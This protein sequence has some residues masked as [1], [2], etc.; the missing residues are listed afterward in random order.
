MKR[1]DRLALGLA[2][3]GVLLVAAW[4]AVAPPAKLVGQGSASKPVSAA[5]TPSRVV[6]TPLPAQ[7]RTAGVPVGLA[8]ITATPGAEPPPLFTYNQ[9]VTPQKEDGYT[10]YPVKIDVDQ[11]L[12]AALSGRMT[13]VTPDGTKVSL[14]YD[15]HITHDDGNW[16]WIGREDSDDTKTDSVITFGSNATFGTLPSVNGQQLKLTTIH[17]KTYLASAPLAQLKEGVRP[18]GDT[19]VTAGGTNVAASASPSVVTSAAPSLSGTIPTVDVMIGF[20]TGY[21]A[22]R[23]GTDVATT[24]ITN[25]VDN[26]N[27]ILLN[28]NVQADF[29]LVGTMEVAYPDTGDN[30]DTLS[31]LA[32]GSTAA[33]PGSLRFYR[34]QYGAD[35]VSLVRRYDTS[36]NGCGIAYIPQA[37]Y[38]TTGP[39]QAFS[40]IG[41]GS[42]DLG[43]G[44]T[45]YCAVTTLAHEMGHNLGAQHNRQTNSTGGLFAFSYGYRNDSAGFYDVMSYGLDG[46]EAERL[47]ST[48]NRSICKGLPCGDAASADVARTL[49]Q[50]MPIAATF[51]ATVGPPVDT[52]QPGQIVGQNGRCLDGRGGSTA[53]GTAV[54]V[55]ACNGLRQQ[56]WVQHP[57]DD[58]IWGGADLVLDVTGYGTTSGTPV[59][60]FAPEKTSNQRWSFHESAIVAAGGRVLDAISFG[61]ANGT[62]LQL[63][64]DVGSPNQRWMF[65]PASGQIRIDTGRC[66]DVQGGGNSLGT[67][68]QLWDC[69]GNPNQTFHLG[70]N[71]S[72]VSAGGLCLD[73]TGYGMTNGTLLQMWNCTGAANQRWRLRGEIRALNSDMCLQDP[74]NGQINGAQTQV[75]ACQG[76]ANQRWEYQPN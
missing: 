29:R 7:R 64:D 22:Y 32:S 56:Q 44:Y 9:E 36:Q 24:A 53:N 38:A 41:D 27:S 19:L 61:S 6:S 12:A 70:P 47:Y 35:L 11:A 15:R 62:R 39:D 57:F 1:K 67:P 50:T 46:Q 3:G 37:N 14:A 74:G 54:Q 4:V 76:T 17:G 26:A 68:V 52:S 75:G 16:T 40:V 33:T 31:L 66:L 43:N 10:L 21:A 60:L 5:S 63:Y 65:Y 8:S 18:G 42:V 73:A 25:L 58:T 20:T 45:S 51:R 71:G 55:W 69:L 13:L 72:I 48:P 49:S 23:G 28:S 2:L 30:G 59:Q 34:D